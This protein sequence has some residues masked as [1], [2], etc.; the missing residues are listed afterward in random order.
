[1]QLYAILGWLNYS[2]KK[3]NYYIIDSMDKSILPGCCRFRLANPHV[4]PIV[5]IVP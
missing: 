3:L 4:A 2:T 1:M 5:D